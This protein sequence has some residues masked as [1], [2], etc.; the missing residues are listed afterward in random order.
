MAYSVKIRAEAEEDLKDA[1]SYFEQCRTGL[2]ADFILCIEESL[3]KISRNPDQYPVIYQGLHR[4]LVR[5]FPYGV[6][7]KTHR[8][9]VVVFAIMHCAREPKK[10]QA[11]QK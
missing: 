3:S 9:T 4:T 7:Y 5:R 11:R 10:W 1:Y 2:G 6:F 8:D